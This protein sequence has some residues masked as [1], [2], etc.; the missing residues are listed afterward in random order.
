MK[1]DKVTGK[2]LVSD[3]EIARLSTL[4]DSDTNKAYVDAQ[5][6]LKVDKVT[7][8]SL[9]A[10]DEIARLS[11][12]VNSDTNKAYVDA[13]A[14]LKVDKVT[15]KSLVSDSEIE[16]LTTVVNSDANKAYVDAQAVLKVDK[17]AGKSL[18][19]DDEIARLS[20]V[21]NSNT[22]KAYVDAQALLKVDKVNGKGLSTEDFSIAEKIKLA[23]IVGNNT[24]DQDLSSFASYVNLDLKADLASPIFTGTPS[25]TTSTVAVTQI[26]GDNSLAVA[27]TEFVSNALN[28][29]IV[30]NV[31][32]LSN[33]QTIDGIKTFSADVIINGI[34]VGRGKFNENSNTA[35]GL[36]PLE[37]NEGYANTGI[38]RAAV[39]ANITG[40]GNTGIG[41]AALVS[42]VS[43]NDNVAIGSQALD[44]NISG[45]Y[46]IAIGQNADV[47]VDGISN[48]VALGSRAI[49]TASNTIQLGNTDV[50]NVKTSGTITAGSV[51]Y[52]NT[53]N[54]TAGQVL[55]VDGSGSATF[56]NASGSG[57]DLTT[58]QTVGGSKSFT[59]NLRIGTSTANPVAALEVSSTTQ[60]LLLPRLTSSQVDAIVNPVAGLLVFNTTQN[61]FQGFIGANPSQPNLFDWYTI[62]IYGHSRIRPSHEIRQTFISQGQ[63]VTS[64]DLA[65][66]R[67]NPES[68]NFGTFKFEIY[69]W[70]NWSSPLLYSSD[71]SISSEGKTTIDFGSSITL[72]KGN[73]YIVITCITGGADFGIG[74]GSQGTLDNSYWQSLG[75]TNP[76]DRP[77]AAT[78]YTN[79]SMSIAK[80]SWHFF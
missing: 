34:T 80:G 64:I 28:T 52:P 41:Y 65:T 4:V 31:V 42:N 79:G 29:A 1:V 6:V 55:T 74:G 17:E 14:V 46:N 77:L 76:S 5:A 40:N 15:G 23:A 51:T 25:L 35:V 26:D 75:Y 48:A 39:A 47:S 2:S 61:S 11:T 78:L 30:A 19:S 71:F 60:G 9:V 53:H 72:P 43:G 49:V 32:D 38:G 22:N 73:C 57:V 70:N 56:A 68:I 8:K 59:E 44:T 54:S 33:N 16:R 12:V 20:T 45:S 63:S 36:G 7:C 18:V 66:V 10:D 3:S 37:F 27:T 69:D 67:V 13:Q 24:G 50:I 21:V 62:A 58:A